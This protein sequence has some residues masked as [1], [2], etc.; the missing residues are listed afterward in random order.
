MS[1]KKEAG[2]A[3]PAA[4]KQPAAS[5]KPGPAK[6]AKPAMEPAAKAARTTAPQ[7][8]AAR[9]AAVAEP[10]P[11]V[12]SPAQ[13][14][15]APP[16]SS[17]PPAEALGEIPFQE[18]SR[19]ATSAFLYAALTP[20]EVLALVKQLGLS[21]PGF[22]PEGLGEVERCDLLA[23]EL[24]AVPR[25]RGPALALLRQAL[26]EPAFAGSTLDA[27]A[28]DELLEVA[29]S[30]HGLAIALWRLVA[31]PKP[32]VRARGA[33]ALERLAGEWYGPPPA[34][35]A[36]EAAG[37]G[38]GGVGEEAG[39]LQSLEEKLGRAEARAEEQRQRGEQRAEKLQGQLKEARSEAA[40]AIDEAARARQATE[41]AQTAQRQAEASLA[42]SRAGA[43][44]GETGRLK[45]ALREA[46]VRLHASE[47]RAV[48]AEERE[49]AAQAALRRLQEQ[50]P[51]P[52]AGPAV[53]TP[54]AEVEPEEA[55][56]A[57]LLPVFSSEF[58]DSLSG[59]DRRIQRA[60][61]KQAFLLSQDH[62][63]PSLR[64]LPLEG[65]PG[66]YRVRVAT[67]VRLIYRRGE[68]QD[69]VEICSLIDR[70]D[71]DRYVRQAKT[72]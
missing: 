11:T 67:D 49:A 53:S 35:Q 60:A 22:R 64:A 59:W 46:E 31:D 21:M 70:E 40:R 36:P 5:K 44:A 68:R 28:A 16:T 12:P 56:A 42:A 15:P 37:R 32:E 58:Y 41:A 48:R 6:K 62:R 19:D 54:D 71:L 4:S 51:L 57:W 61:L 18:L 66:Y 13:L 7:A 24:R 8:G 39:R 1:P 47:A 27:A 14:P 34:G 20:D 3:R 45:G 25:A 10:A 30:D 17:A 2:G 65:L 55:P 50:T 29:G 9:A 26:Q 38:P 63:H 52:G 43:A 72:R 23:D 69:T 33:A